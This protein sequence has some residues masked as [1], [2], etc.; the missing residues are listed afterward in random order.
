MEKDSKLFQAI[1]TE[2]YL[3]RDLKPIQLDDTILEI[4]S[5]DQIGGDL[6]CSAILAKGTQK[7]YLIPYSEEK[8][9]GKPPP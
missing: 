5:V 6:K 4:Q 1:R 9:S 8:P 2:T 7:L 3:L